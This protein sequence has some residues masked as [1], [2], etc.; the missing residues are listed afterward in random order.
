ML[1]C[2]RAC[3]HLCVWVHAYI[4]VWTMANLHSP[5]PPPTPTQCDAAT[6]DRVIKSR[7]NLPYG[8][9]LEI[10][11]M[12]DKGATKRS[13]ADRYKIN[14]STVR[15][16]Y[17]QRE[18][19]KAHMRLAPSAP[20]S[21]ALR[22]PNQL[23]LKTEHL[24]VQYIERQ[25]RQNFPVDTRKI[26]KMAKE[27]YASV[28]CKAGIEHPKG[29]VASKGWVEKFMERHKVKSVKILDEATRGN[30]THVNEHPEIL[31][32]I[33]AAGQCTSDK[34]FN[35]DETNFSLK[36][37][38]HYTATSQLV[39]ISGMKAIT[40]HSTM[41]S[42][43]N[44]SRS[45]QLKPKGEKT[46]LENIREVLW[47]QALSVQDVLL[48]GA[49]EGDNSAGDPEQ[50]QETGQGL[51]I[52]DIK[53]LVELGGQIR[54]ILEKDLTNNSE[55]SMYHINQ[56]LA[57]YED[58]YRTH[59]NSLYQRQITSYFR[60]HP[61][62]PPLPKP[63]N[64]QQPGPSSQCNKDVMS[65]VSSVDFKKFDAEEFLDESEGRGVGH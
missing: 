55:M 7:K 29:F 5:C 11:Q 40:E 24:L 23:L 46:A 32:Q 63:D 28:A 44:D 59:I 22:S 47:P 12:I 65:V 8:M 41:L 14:E 60:K 53:C 25:T 19:I 50:M 1:V 9:K 6:P 49:E 4:C 38:P 2:A 17:K 15:G 61:E 48:E 16:I 58:I 51:A 3:M 52:A 26:M 21:N 20:A 56:A 10:V 42:A 45:C 39:K 34:I 37:M 35:T 36:T 43:M 62:T 18:H 64:E 33:I 30:K 57:G 31:R 13:V 54:Q 27:I